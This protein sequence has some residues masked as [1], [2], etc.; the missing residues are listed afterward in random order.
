MARKRLN[1]KVALIGSVVFVFLVLVVV[2]GILYL[3]QAPEKFIKDGDVAM[4]AAEEAIDEEVKAEEYKKAELNYHRAHARA[5]TDELKIK[6]L[7]KLVD[8]YLKTGEW[9][10]IRGCWNRIIQTDPKNVK[11]RFGRLK[12]FYIVAD[13]GARGVWREVESQASEFL[14]IAD[15]DLLMEDAAKWES[16]ETQERPVGKPPRLGPY[17]YLLRGRA[18]L[19]MAR[20]GA[21]TNPED[22]LAQAIDDLEKVRELEPD[23]VD[24]CWY[25]AQAIIAKGDI[26]ASRGNLE[27]R[28]KAAEQ[29]KELL[30]SQ[31][32]ET[33]VVGADPSAH[34]NLVK[35]KT[36]IMRAQRS[37]A[38]LSEEQI[39][40]LDP[41]Y[42]SI[43]DKF[44]ASAEAHSELA[45]FYQGLGAKDLD[46]AIEAIEK[47][48]ELDRENVAYAMRAASLYYRRFSVLLAQGQRKRSELYKAIEMAKNALT[49]PNA[50]DKPGPRQLT[51]KSNKTLLYV[52]LANCYIEQVLELRR[53][54]I[55]TESESREWLTKAEEVVH[56]VEQLYGSGE[57]PQ[58]V[59]W[60]GMLE[61]ARG[62]EDIAIHPLY[63][64]Y[65]QIKASKAPDQRDAQLSYTLAKAFENTSE[66][67][68][69]KE[70]LESAIL[71]GIALTKPNSLLDYVDV[72][73]KLKAY[74]DSLSVIN[75][76]EDNFWASER[77][78]TLRIR[79]YI[80]AQQ[81]DKAEEELAKGL[82]DDPKTIRLG[83]ALLR[84]KIRQVR[85]AI[86]R[87]QREESSGIISQGVSG[88]EKEG[89]ELDS[90]R[91]EEHLRTSLEGA[92]ELMRAELKGYNDALAG[93]VDK[94]LAVEPNS[95]TGA[96]V[97]IVC[98]NY[99]AEGKMS[100]ASDLVNRFL[101]YFP[102]GIR[103][104]FYKQLISEPEPSKVSQ[105]RR[106]EIEEELLLNIADPIRRSINLGAFY[107]RN[108]EP[109]KAVEEF[110]KVLE[111]EALQDKEG[112]VEESVFDSRRAEKEMMDLQRLA[113]S[114]LSDIAFRTKDRK[115][116]EQIADIS[117][118]ANLDD[119]EGKFFAAVLA[120]IK[121]EYKDA[122]A[123]VDECLRQRPVFSYGY[124]LRSSINAALGNEHASIEDAQK[125]TALNPLDGDIA[126]LLAN[127]LY[128]RDRKLGDN[129]SS[130]QII[131]TRR[132]L[133]K[134]MRLNPNDLRLLS[135]YAEYISEEKPVEALAIR[136]RLQEAIPS[137]RNALLLGNMAMRMAL[138][139]TNAERKKFLFDT[140]GSSFEQARAM[141]PQNKD[142]LEAQARYYRLTG[143]E[144]KAEEL[145]TQSQDKKL[146][147]S[148]YLQNG[149]FDNAKQ[150]LERLYQADAEDS[151]VVKGL[152]LVAEKTGDGEAIKKYSE[153]LLSLEDSIENHLFQIQTFLKIGFVKE[154]E[155]KLQSFRERYPD[156]PRALLFEAWLT[157]RKGQ[158]KKALEL[159]NRNLEI[160]QDNVVAWRLRG[161]INRL[162]AN[163]D[164]AIIDLKKSKSL[165]EDLATQLAL[166]KVYLRAGRAED[167]I[168]ELENMVYNPQA[169]MESGILLERIYWRLGRREA[170]KKFYDEVLKRFP[171]N[172]LWYN[173]AGEFALAARNF[174]AAERL[175]GLALQKGEGGGGG[176]TAALDGY[177]RALLL[178]GKLNKLFQEAGKYVDG[179]SAPIAYLRMAEAKMKLGDETDAIRYCRKAVDKAGTNEEFVFNIL[180]KMHSLLGPKKVM[181][182]CREKLEANPDSLAANYTMFNMTKISGEYNKAASYIDKCLQIIGPD[183]PKRVDYVMQKAIIFQL[184]YTKTSDNNYLM[185]AIAEYE[186]LLAKMPNNTGVLNNLAYMLAESNER[187]TDALEYAKRAHEAKPN[188]PDLMDTY[189][190][191]LYKNG[192]FTEA[193]EL[194]Q[195]ALQQYEQK[196]SSVPAEVYEH[197]G[198]IEE[199]LGSVTKALA[200][201]KQALEIGEDTLSE[202]S[203]KRIQAVVE[204]LSQ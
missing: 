114:S 18:M 126:K 58:V 103:V 37:G 41:E 122:L 45:E 141:G 71:A 81:F 100:E 163:Y 89:V 190:Y 106:K 176:N 200:A 32:I 155:Y 131:E 43:V 138:R 173:R 74:G 135:F 146:L 7:F 38:L 62:N 70:F 184:A 3:S 171:D 13:G 34:I 191:V 10:Y 133:I 152:L 63:V 136:E 47:A 113:A 9:N 31:V 168:T 6:M 60:R 156:E 101:E 67:G 86:A 24:A 69:V 119:C 194:L 4:K 54:G 33:G 195:A 110:K 129:V 143:Q 192:R 57:D 15:P 30:E 154:A 147:W 117:K 150:V 134:A 139:E 97:A 83:V 165:S 25:L 92:D 55:G 42:L 180:Q 8:V 157:M 149:Q 127:V 109:N 16:F 151:D 48:I 49:L 88:V 164:Q 39:Q 123:S 181:R 169:P 204:R 121:E 75:F 203:K 189:A 17:L 148:H 40:T 50:Q 59:K 145:L 94:L 161:E 111:V 175:F 36:A 53:A 1:K 104:L 162:M 185:R 128:R 72:L 130:D 64:A 22:S 132:A 166:A 196:K 174:R 112:V 56:E 61:L 177:L 27:E 23:N 187:P 29:A 11:A 170:L 68:A 159:A 26:L 79:A 19:E 98:A 188:N 182:Y 95:L 178:G 199:E 84:A 91:D 80:G 65:E 66:I 90:E 124:R 186:S 197:L 14:E 120:M 137:A 118:R 142:V 140:A 202:A 12:Y 93:L 201:Y 35:M 102:D 77:S 193:A 5:K 105:Q 160:D 85:M 82:L 21:V 44:P 179:Y 99:I 158:L 116:A 2:A 46:K 144:E 172:L 96:T 198:M 73:L 52:F 78:Q 28:D 115:L 20:M 183:N 125:A 167:A 153:E 51:N 76:F 107:Q 87:K 108:N